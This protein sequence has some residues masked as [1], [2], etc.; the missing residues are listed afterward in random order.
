MTANGGGDCPERQL[1]ALLETLKV[2]DPDGY[3]AMIPGSEIVLLTDAPSHATELE[4]LVIDEAM[5][6]KVCIS[7]FL[8]L[9]G[10]CIH[11]AGQR[12]YERIANSTGGT[13]ASSI[14]QDGFLD[15]ASSH[16]YGKCANKYDL[17][18]LFGQRKK[19][20]TS[21]LSSSD[22]YNS[23]QE[24]HNFSTS[25]FTTAVK[26]T[27]HTS[28]HSVIVTKPNGER[29]TVP[30]IH[31]VGAVFRDPTPLSGEWSVC[32]DNG[33]LTITLENKDGMDNILKYLRPIA[34]SSEFAIRH[35]PPPACKSLNILLITTH[36]IFFFP[37][38]AQPEG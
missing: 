8:S 32:V 10:G 11:E 38:Q 34:N 29:I 1:D 28:Q 25:L 27:G 6:S 9:T 7:F 13:V 3:E 4:K 26:V 5:V 33:T 20:Q 15:F 31:R 14:S 19:R 24:C 22:T 35:T 16:D 21:S 18:Q 36:N 30:T 17:P 23:E 2:R 12:M 37:A